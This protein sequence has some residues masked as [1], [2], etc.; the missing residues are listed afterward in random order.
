MGKHKLLIHWT[1]KLYD[2]IARY[3]DWMDRLFPIGRRGH[4]KILEGEVVGSLLDIACGTGTLLALACK[5]GLRCS[6]M[7]T[8][9]GMLAQA[10]RKAPGAKFLQASFYE[11]PFPEG[12]FDYVVETNA[13]SG[14]EIDAGQVLREMIRVCKPGGE[15][16][17]SDYAKP[18][19]M[20]RLSQSIDRVLQYIGDYAYDYKALFNGFG[21]DPEVEVLGWG[22]MYQFIRVRK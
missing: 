14:V 10:E 8:S 7:D 18:V 20:T 6:G 5:R 12:T 2:R 1:P 15:L 16:R 19:A 17:L 4:E 21:Y 11:I 3:Y 22:G 13:V 9:S